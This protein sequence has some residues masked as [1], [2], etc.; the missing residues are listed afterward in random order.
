[1]IAKVTPEINAELLK[2]FTKE[3]VE[4]ALHQMASLK[5]LGLDGFNPSFFQKYWHIVGNVL[6]SVVL[7]FL[8]GSIFDSCI[9]F[10]FIA[11]IPKIK[12]PIIAFDFK[13]ISLC[14]IIYKLTS[15]VLANRLK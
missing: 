6:S 9:N 1:M 3:K 10:T 2:Q 13:L 8:N 15:K 14:N 7:K 5:F 12:C 11:L 4:L